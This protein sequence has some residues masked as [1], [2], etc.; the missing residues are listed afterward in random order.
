MFVFLSIGLGIYALK[1]I[2]QKKLK[3]KGLAIAGLVL[4]SIGL[5]IAIAIIIV[6]LQNFFGGQAAQTD[7]NGNVVRDPE[8]FKPFD[9]EQKFLAPGVIDLIKRIVLRL[10]L[11]KDEVRQ[12]FVEH[13][14]RSEKS[15]R[16]PLSTEQ[17]WSS[18]DKEL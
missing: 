3:G 7:E 5:I 18:V 6:S 12:I 17:A 9:L 16:L 2:K 4:G 14:S 10:K 11:S 8:Y 13:N 15:L 1:Q